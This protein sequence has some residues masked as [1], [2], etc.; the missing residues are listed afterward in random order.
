MP[1][2][3]VGASQT[4]ASSNEFNNMLLSGVQ[5]LNTKVQAS[6]DA[7]QNYILNNNISTHELMIAM[8]QAKHAMEIAVEVR[9]KAVEAYQQI[10]RMQI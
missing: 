1:M 2:N 5:Q 4:D 10:V 3:T 8:E 9:N 6:E 7:L